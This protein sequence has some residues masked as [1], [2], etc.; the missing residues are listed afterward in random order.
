MTDEIK[1]KGRPKKEKNDEE[2][3]EKKKRGRKKKEDNET[4]IEIKQKKKRGRKATLKY[5]NSDIRKKI[6]MTT[7]HMNNNNTI[8]HLDL[9]DDEEENEFNIECLDENII[10]DTEK[11]KNDIQNIEN[12]EDLSV[13]YEKMLVL[14]EKEENLIGIVE[15]NI[16]EEE[17]EEDK[18]EERN[19]N[20][21][22][23][24]KKLLSDNW[25]HQTD[26]KCWWC[27][28]SFDTVP[29][30]KPYSWDKNHDKFRV[31]GIFCSF[32]C[33][34][35]YHDENG[36]ME[37]KYLMNS[38]YYKLTGNDF[39]EL[40]SA[41]S[42]YLLKMFGG[43]LTI[44]EFRNTNNKIFKMIEYPMIITRDFVEEVDINNM[45][46]INKK[47]FTQGS[48]VKNTSL[49]KIIEDAKSRVKI[50]EATVVKGNTIDKFI[51]F[52]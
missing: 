13:L 26:Y 11:I 3:L 5:Y 25:V 41:P 36:R 12:E 20:F 43:Q 49:D 40:K 19:Y 52:V 50:E 1:K 32:E 29:L 44:D 8:I 27:C 47:L 33:M 18:C 23:M 28:H 15:N 21:F 51:Q 17:K 10:Q 2:Q 38:M 39:K 22:Q 7:T 16:E 30:G 9:E 35:A 4:V 45:K 14:R 37:E 46:S 6:Q 48:E 42:K 34:K 31:R 24:Y